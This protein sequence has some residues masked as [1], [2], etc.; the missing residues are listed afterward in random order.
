MRHSRSLSFSAY[1]KQAGKLKLIIRYFHPLSPSNR[2]PDDRLPLLPERRRRPPPHQRPQ[3]TKYARTYGETHAVISNF[4]L[5]SSGAHQLRVTVGDTVLIF[6]ELEDWYYGCLTQDRGQMGIFPKNFV[7]V[8]DAC[9]AS[10]FP[11]FQTG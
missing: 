9:P 3:N 5:N 4:N 6:E 7:V 1:I 11:F 8:R 10:S 2:S